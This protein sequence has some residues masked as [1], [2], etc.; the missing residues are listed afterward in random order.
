MWSR[1]S[2]STLIKSKGRFNSEARF[3]MMVERVWGSV[4]GCFSLALVICLQRCVVGMQIMVGRDAGMNNWVTIGNISYVDSERVWRDKEG[5]TLLRQSNHERHA[6]YTIGVICPGDNR[7][8]SRLCWAPT[9]KAIEY[10]KE[11]ELWRGW[12][13]W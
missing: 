8:Q 10:P 2:L 3:G 13:N 11:N 4:E 1:T 6:W 9:R 5:V 12:C 7:C